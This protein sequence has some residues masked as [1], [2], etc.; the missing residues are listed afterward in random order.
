MAANTPASTRTNPSLVSVPRD[1]CSAVMARPVPVSVPRSS[2]E[3]DFARAPR[4]WGSLPDARQLGC[5]L[6]LV[7]VQKGLCQCP[8]PWYC[9]P[10]P[11]FLFQLPVT[12]FSYF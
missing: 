6:A 12:A 4:G 5:L 10:A 11:T 8:E 1:M 9:S 2:T 7:N 3:L